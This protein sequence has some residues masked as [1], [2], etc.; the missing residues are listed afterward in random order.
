MIEHYRRRIVRFWRV[1]NRRIPPLGISLLLHLLLF[2]AILLAGISTFQ[3]RVPR[4]SAPVI[5]AHAVDGAV[6]KAQEERKRLEQERAEQRKR[7]KRAAQKRKKEQEQARKREKREKAE[8]LKKK[9]AKEQAIKEEKTRKAAKRKRAEEKKRRAQQEK[10][11][12]KKELE[13]AKKRAEKKKA[14]RHK[15]EKRAAEQ[16]KLQ[17]QLLLEAEMEL[18]QQLLSGEQ[19]SRA[20]RQELSRIRMA[21]RQQIERVWRKPRNTPIGR[22]CKIAVVLLPDG[23]VGRVTILSSSGNQQ[24][25]D[26]VERAIH[27]AAPF[28]LPESVELRAEIR[29]LEMTF[30]HQG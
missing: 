17:Q 12:K 4:Q 20:E 23:G 25:D 30:V 26:S 14:E 29:E 9:R 19:Q 3:E 1:V 28:P 21:I 10:L 24:F 8:G 18:E 13:R 6:L 5:R 15:A 11:K 7:E 27:E 22:L 2:G 16:K